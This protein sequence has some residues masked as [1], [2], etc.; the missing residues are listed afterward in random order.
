MKSGGAACDT[1]E[2]LFDLVMAARPHVPS[3]AAEYGLTE[4]QCHLLRLLG[5]QKP[6]T[7]RC[8]A[9]ALACDASNITGIVD[10]LEARGLVARRAATHDRR[11]KELV[12]TPAGATLRAE[13]AQRLAQ[14][15]AAIAR[16]S[17]EDQRALRNL[18]R[19]ALAR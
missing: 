5:D 3:V 10:R 7:M 15:P 4:A 9:E 2:L 17:A 16:L 11:V 6:V 19:K 13:L 8:L 12:L 18:L 14:P 1:W